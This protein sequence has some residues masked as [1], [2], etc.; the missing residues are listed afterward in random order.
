MVAGVSNVRMRLVGRF[1]TCTGD[2]LLV[3]ILVPDA[4]VLN[5]KHFDTHQ[6]CLKGES[7]GQYRGQG[8]HA[9]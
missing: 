2:L 5:A 9:P 7:N 6:Y 8:W 3:R 1:Q 4:S